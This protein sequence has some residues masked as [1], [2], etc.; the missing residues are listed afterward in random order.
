M[1]R[2]IN[3]QTLAS[4]LFF[5]L[6]MLSNSVYSTVLLGEGAEQDTV[7]QKGSGVVYL[8]I[9]FYTPETKLAGGALVNYYYR[10]SGSEIT[11]RLHPLCHL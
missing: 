1:K 2:N 9:L 6:L 8:P 10:E 5:S 4:I 7:E 3:I 11:S